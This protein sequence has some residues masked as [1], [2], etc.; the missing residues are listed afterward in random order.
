VQHIRFQEM[1]AELIRVLNC[2][3]RIQP[4]ARFATS[5]LLAGALLMDG[6]QLLY[7]N[8]IEPYSR[9]PTLDSHFE[10]FDMMST[11]PQDGSI[12]GDVCAVKIK[13]DY[14][15][16]LVISTQIATY[17]VVSSMRL[18]KSS[19]P[20]LGPTTINF[21]PSSRTRIFCSK[22]AIDA[23][24]RVIERKQ[25][26]IFELGD[27]LSQLRQVRSKFDS[28]STYLPCRA[29]SNLTNNL[30]CR[31]FTIWTIADCDDNGS[32][33]NDVKLASQTLQAVALGVLTRDNQ[34]LYL[35]DLHHL[36]HACHSKKST[37]TLTNIQAIVAMF[38]NETEPL[39]IIHNQKLDKHLRE[40]AMVATSSLAKANHDTKK[41]ISNIF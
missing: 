30:K 20:E 38:K 28:I 12:Y 23:A 11:L 5:A 1:N 34:S 19:V 4:A 37:N 36:I 41:H 32:R 7:I 9:L 31:P 27:T 25:M 21:D 2:D 40:L 15:E 10:R 18:D 29:T 14:A 13:D 24:K 39:P 6:H 16:K 22:N 26:Q 35:S 33:T 3:W 17:L 8:S